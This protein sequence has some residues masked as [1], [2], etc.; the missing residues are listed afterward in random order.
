MVF[1][2]VGY[3]AQLAYLRRLVQRI[4]DPRLAGQFRFLM[5]AFGA[6]FTILAVV[7]AAMIWFVGVR[8]FAGGTPAALPRAGSN[9]A[10]AGVLLGV[11][12][13]AGIAGL[14][15]F[16]FYIVYLVRLGQLS[17][18]LREQAAA[19]RYIWSTAGS[20]PLQGGAA[21][22]VRAPGAGPVILPAPPPEPIPAPAPRPPADA[23]TQVFEQGS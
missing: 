21:A 8:F 11:G 6:C 7:G 20:A 9:G 1:Q 17:G 12:L 22:A 19:A 10:V 5:Y 13:A 14:A 18:R 4:P 23:P 3:V 2:V 16:V 15:V